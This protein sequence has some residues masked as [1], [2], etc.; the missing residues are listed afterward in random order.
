M[1]D[2]LLVQPCFKYIL[3]LLELTASKATSDLTP[4]RGGPFYFLG[5]GWGGRI[6]T[7]PLLNFSVNLLT[8]CVF[9]LLLKIPSTSR[10]EK[11]KYHT[12][13]KD[14]Q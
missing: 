10:A 2:N 11:H 14:F 3:F 1:T 13:Y 6:G 12:D 5:G 8:T 4:P 7:V 9:A